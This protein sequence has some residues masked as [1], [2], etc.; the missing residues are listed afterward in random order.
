MRYRAF[1]GVFRTLAEMREMRGFVNGG[2]NPAKRT[3]DK[4]AHFCYYEECRKKAS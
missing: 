3:V 4:T 2:C 1:W